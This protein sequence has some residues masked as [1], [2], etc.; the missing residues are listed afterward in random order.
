MAKSKN[1]PEH[2]LRVTT[3]AQ[4]QRYTQAFA[5]GHLNLL[6]LCGPAGSAKSTSLSNA[7]GD[8]ACYI[9]G[10][11]TAFG[12]YLQAYEHQN[13]LIILDDVDGLAR[14][15][16]GVRLLKSLCQSTPVKTLGWYTDARTLDSRGIPNQFTTT[17]QVAIIANRWQSLNADVQALEDRGHFLLFEPSAVEVH[18]QAGTWFWD[19]QIFDFVAEHLHLIEQPSLRTY[20]LAWE[21]KEAGLDWR[22]GVLSRCLT[23]PALQVAQLKADPAFVSEEDRVAAFVASGSGCRA[24]YFNHAKK[25]QPVGSPP[26]IK[27]THSEPYLQT[28]PSQTVLDLLRQRFGQLGNG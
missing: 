1:L 4:L 26:S 20:I 11:A 23:G 15:R 24:T 10:N 6:V 16:N 7:V 2:V 19:Q 28:G 13:E 27:L 14:D 18:C 8:K 3:Y 17:S 9:D 25:L 22:Q 21:L 12:I 5:K